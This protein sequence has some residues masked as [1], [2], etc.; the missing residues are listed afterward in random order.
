MVR[1]AREWWSVVSL[2]HLKAVVMLRRPD[3]EVGESKC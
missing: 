2:D 3:K 1:I